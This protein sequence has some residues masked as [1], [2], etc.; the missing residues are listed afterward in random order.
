M[1]MKTLKT[2]INS[3]TAWDL[4][5]TF[6]AE[7]KE[8]L[9]YGPYY[10]GALENVSY[11][12]GKSSGDGKII[13]EIKHKHHEIMKDIFEGVYIGD[14]PHDPYKLFFEKGLKV[15]LKGD[16]KHSI[17]HVEDLWAEESYSKLTIPPKRNLLDY[18]HQNHQLKGKFLRG[19]VNSHYPRSHYWGILTD[20]V[21]VNSEI[22]GNGRVLF[23][24]SR[25]V[26]TNDLLLYNQ[27]F[28]PGDTLL[29]DAYLNKN[30]IW[31]VNN[32]KVI[33]KSNYSTPIQPYVKKEAP[34][35]SIFPQVS[36]EENVKKETILERP[37]RNTLYFPKK[38]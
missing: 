18:I 8:R 6:L 30:L 26:R 7:L 22:N 35:R 21:D 11:F 29:I 5:G 9:D 4:Q 20:V 2:I 25:R 16:L 38:P 13:F 3:Q 37:N 1:L 34:P 24:I 17:C 32:F 27:L 28:Q 15:F 36:L 23:Q 19:T 10:R 31:F 33:G 14:I 12:N